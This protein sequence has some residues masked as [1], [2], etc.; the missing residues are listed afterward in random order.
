[1]SLLTKKTIVLI[2]LLLGCVSAFASSESVTMYVGDTKTL[3]LPASVTSKNIKS[4]Y[5]VATSPSYADIS[6]HTMFSV[7]V[8][9]KKAIST[10]VII[11]CDYTY[12]VLRNGKYVYGG[13]GFH[14]FNI[15]VKNVPVSYISLPETKTLEVGEAM[16]LKP[17]ISPSNATPELTWSSSNY[18]IVSVDNNGRIYAKSDGTAVITV[19]TSDGKSASCTVTAYRPTIDVTSVSVSPESLTLDVGNESTLTATV[20]PSNATTKTITWSSSDTGV[21]TVTSSG[22]VKAVSE[23]RATIYAKSNNGIQGSCAVTCKEPLPDLTLADKED[24]PSDIPAMANVTYQR[25]FYKGWNSLCVPFAVKASYIKGCKLVVVKDNENSG[26]KKYFLFTNVEEVAAGTPCL[27]WVEKDT[28]C[29]LRLKD[30][31][32]VAQPVN[33]GIMKGSYSNAV[34]GAGCYKL[35]SDGESFSLTTG[36][37][38]TVTAYRTYIKLQ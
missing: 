5:F 25:T 32:L 18:A 11:R 19:K 27:V 24:I 31:T 29:N 15:T 21:A 23:G 4:C 7:T 33:T 36:E 10:P 9:A 1:M 14:D 8:V 30:Q 20:Y 17:T 12:Y 13:T 2:L 26:P 37:E 28:E 35:T 6:S 34:I 22:K 38:A 3:Y 16:T